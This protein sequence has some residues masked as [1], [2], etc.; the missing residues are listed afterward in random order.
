MTGDTEPQKVALVTGGSSGLGAQI[1]DRLAQ[2]GWTVYAG[3]RRGTL[4]DGAHPDVHP[5][6]CDVTAHSELSQAVAEIL[7][8]Q[9]HLDAIICNAGINVSALAEE[10]PETRAQA[11]L[12]TNFWGA[13]YGARATLPHFRAQRAGTIL[14]IGSLAGMV[15]P[16][17]EAYYAASK[18]GIRGFLESL[19]YEVAG[20]GIRVHLI[21][22][23]FIRTNLANA[24]APNTETLTDYDA[25]RARLQAHWQGAIAGGLEAKEVADRVVHVLEH[26]DAPFRMRIGRDAVWIPRLKALLPSRIFFALTRRRFGLEG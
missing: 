6:R 14:V 12:N 18:H 13:V 26:P 22:P 19:Q 3:S 16:P 1:C 9:G 2:A 21:E 25:V 23:G 8:T 15:S 17:G 24:S 5:I 11:I 20:F 4:M 7:Q 10:L